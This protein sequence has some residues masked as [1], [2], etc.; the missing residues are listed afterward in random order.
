MCI[1]PANFKIMLNGTMTY[2][3]MKGV[4]ES[5]IKLGYD[6]FFAD[7]GNIIFTENEMKE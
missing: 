5:I 1:Q 2:A 4:C 3:E 7:N 6:C